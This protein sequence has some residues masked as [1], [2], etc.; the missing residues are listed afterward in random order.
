MTI[1]EINYLKT[2]N[3]SINDTKSII[4][5][6]AIDETLFKFKGHGVI[7]AYTGFGKGKMGRDVVERLKTKEPDASIIVLVPSIHLREDW[8]NKLKD[9]DDI[10]VFVLNTYT[11]SL[12]DVINKCDLLIIDEVHHVLG[13]DSEY[14]STALQ[15]TDRRFTFGFTAKLS[16]AQESYLLENGIEIS[17]KIELIDGI[18]LGLV[19]S[20]RVLNLPVPFTEKEQ[21][22]YYKWEKIFNQCNVTFNPV[23]T[24][25]GISLWKVASFYANKRVKKFNT[26]SAPIYK[27]LNVTTEPPREFNIPKI[28]FIT[29][30]AKFLEMD[31]RELTQLLFFYNKSIR[32]R[33]VIITNAVNKMNI[34]KEFIETNKKKAI[35]FAPNSLELSNRILEFGKHSNVVAYNS[36]VKSAKK[37]REILEAFKNDAFNNLLTIKALDEGFD[38]PN[39]EVG[40]LMDVIGN[41]A[42]N[43][44]R[45][46]RLLRYDENNP[47][48]LAVLIY[49]HMDS[50][51][52]FDNDLDEMVE[53]IPADQKRLRWAQK[54]L[55]NIYNINSL[56]EYESLCNA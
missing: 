54:D 55:L 8:E 12:K 2:L 24:I 28:D 18:K 21:I 23:N 52:I 22:D 49:V 46:G 14:F 25:S 5:K 13:E 27:L 15:K 33:E 9:Y 4:Q 30:L 53:V 39:I 26:P 6:K 47:D 31:Y 45:L 36:N 10:K 40:L 38:V 19:P 43:I 35:I 48:K 41:A 50:Y 11:I 56:Q 3:L 42:N 29:M 16:D 34:A 17:Y 51:E 32:E 20:F 7:E 1:Q 44:Q 37:K